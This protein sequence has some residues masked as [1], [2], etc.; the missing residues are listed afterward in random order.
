MIAVGDTDVTL[1]PRLEH[2]DYLCQ[3]LRFRWPRGLDVPLTAVVVV[4]QPYGFRQSLDAEVRRDGGAGE[5]TFDYPLVDEG[6]FACRPSKD[7]EGRASWGM[8]AYRFELSLRDGET[9]VARGAARLDPN[10]LFGTIGGQR[11]AQVDSL[12][13]FVE[14]CPERPAFLDTTQ[15][16]FTIRTLPAR[17]PSCAVEVDVVSARTRQRV[18]GP[19][20]LQLYGEAQRHCFEAAGWPRGEYWLRAQVQGSSG[21]IGAYLVRQ[22]YLETP[23]LPRRPQKPLRIGTVPQYMVDGWLFATSQG[24]RHAPD[25][26]EQLSAGPLADIDRPWEA[27][28]DHLPLESLRVDAESGEL[29]ATYHAGPLTDDTRLWKMGVASTLTAYSTRYLCLAT[30]ADGVH[31]EKPS[32]GRVD[33]QGSRD[34]NILRDRATEAYLLSGDYDSFPVPVKERPLPAKY[35]YRFY[36]RRRDGPVDMDNFV[37]RVFLSANMEPADQ[38]EGGFRPRHQEF[39]GFERR[40]DTF[41]ALTRRPVLTGGRGMHLRQTN[42][43]ASTY[44]FEGDPM[45]LF[46][47]GGRSTCTYYHRPSKTFHYYYRHDYPAYPPKGLPYYL[48]HKVAAIRTRAVMWT[49]DGIH[50]QRRYMTMPDEHDP[51]GTTLYGFGFLKPADREVSDT[52]GQL[53]LGALLNWD[54]ATQTHRQHLMWSRDL[55]HWGKFGGSRVP[56][57]ENG[58][59]GSWNTSTSGLCDYH[60]VTGADG[61]EAWLFPF[62]GTSCRYMLGGG[63]ASGSLDEF[64]RQHPHYELAPFFTGWEALYEEARGYRVLTGLAR[65][66]AGRLAHVEPAGDRGELTTLPL[67]AEGLRLLIN[68]QTESGGSIRVEVQDA[69]GNPFPG[70]GLA[71]CV[72]LAGD[73]TAL[74]VRWRRAHLE[75]VHRRVIR[76]RMVLEGARLYSFR[77]AT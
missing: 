24:L 65:C 49:R 60:A 2:H 59:V 16:A 31:W 3:G 50:W 30:S 32:L 42:E 74:L 28:P 21:P 72:P 61:E 13:Q 26:L 1:R 55:V 48:W 34:N 12:R 5:V 6:R 45:A 27:G 47:P 35:R 75:E 37:F 62:T 15:I 33:F 40:G 41:L 14:C 69:E 18:A 8:G 29:R 53:Y 25:Q 17:V 77:L 68:G 11:L 56:L 38:F 70:L 64:R 71:D 23:H 20:G 36:D 4:T 10:T 63:Q 66:R 73:G 19:L 76:L 44:P 43:R 51:P 67:V 46:Q 22:V 7:A 54:L 52:D 57:L 39:W 9:V 58:P